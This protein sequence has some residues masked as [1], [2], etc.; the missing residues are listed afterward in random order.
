MEFLQ[1]C[2]IVFFGRVVDM[3]LCTMRTILSVREKNVLAAVMGLFEAFI[4]FMVVRQ[5]LSSNIS[6][7]EIAL[8]YGLGFAV[9]TFVG[10]VITRRFLT[11]DLVTQVVTSSRNDELIHTLREEGFAVTVVNVNSSEFGG[12]KYMIFSKIKSNNFKAF[13]A[14]INKFDSHAFIMVQDTKYVFNGYARK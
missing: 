9:G 13:K 14:L 10:G 11:F 3:S 8:V 7:W 4:W 6:G 5:A 1:L 2:L 12:E